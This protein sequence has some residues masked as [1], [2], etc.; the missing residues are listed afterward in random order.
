MS[1]DK[2]KEVIAYNQ[3]DNYVKSNFLISAKYKSSLLENKI[4]AISLASLVN[5]EDCEEDKKTSILYSHL[6]A[7]K[8][9]HALG[10]N[11]GS[12]YSRLDSI[13][14]S[15]A[16]RVIG[17]TSPETK[18]F[19]YIS[20]IS[21]AYYENGVF[22]IGYNPLIKNYIQNLEINFTTLNLKLMVSF[23]NVYSF[24]L[25][26]ILKS[27]AYYPKGQK[28]SENV[29]EIRY[30]LSELK[31]ELGVANANDEKIKA[32]MGNTYNPNFDEAYEKSD[33]KIYTTWYEFRRKVLDVAV[34]EINKSKLSDMHISYDIIKGGVGGKVQSVTFTVTLIDN[35]EKQKEVSVPKMSPDD[36]LDAIMDMFD[37]RLKIKDVKAIAEAAEYDLEKVKKA[38]EVMNKSSSDV[39]NV[40]G[41]IISAIKN[42]YDVVEKKKDK[43]DK[44]AG[45]K[46]KPSKNSFN[47]FE[48]NTYDFEELEKDLLAN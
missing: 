17:T 35:K 5:Y 18:K 34:Q 38:Y 20:V 28:R 46:S 6:S 4:M 16:G 36:V 25:Y 1:A 10:G 2:Q 31:F 39:D 21:H 33:E 27:K 12:F 24:R 29:F 23:K 11:Q 22:T 14:K 19:E 47:E 3:A 41:F 32:L 13:A 30:G 45:K 43:P 7:A 15:M 26:E 42:D 37:I 48:Q 8:L 44:K 9:R 40:V